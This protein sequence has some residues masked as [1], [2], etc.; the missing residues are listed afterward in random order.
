[1][2]HLAKLTPRM[3]AL[4]QA[5]ALPQM[6][7]CPAAHAPRLPQISLFRMEAL[8]HPPQVGGIAPPPAPVSETPPLAE[9]SRAGDLSALRKAFNIMRNKADS[10]LPKNNFDGSIVEYT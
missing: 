5:E 7:Q 1:M 4:P 2:S 9:N 10:P 8:P 3:E 6:R